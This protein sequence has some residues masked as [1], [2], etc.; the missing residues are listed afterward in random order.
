VRID[1]R[2][3]TYTLSY[4]P[5]TPAGMPVAPMS[6]PASARVVPLPTRTAAAPAARLTALAEKAYR[7]LKRMVLENEVHGGEYLL[8]EDLARI[9]G[10][11]RT[12]LR[13]ALVQ[14]QNEGLITIVPRR[15]VRVVPLTVEDMREVY[16]LLRWLESQAAHALACRT[17]RA[18]AVKG[19]R[20]LV[21]QMKKALAAN[22]IAGWARANDLFH[23]RLVESAGNQR[24]VRICAN[25]LDQSQR[26]RA[27]TLR[28]RK[29]PTR[30]TE[31]HAAMLKA[32]E[33]G[34]A[35]RAA[36]LQAQ[37]KQ[38][39]LAEFEDIVQRLQ[40]RYL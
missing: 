31:A 14:L 21:L 40:L 20:Q 3:L 8:E 28:L 6:S 29:P 38:A 13:E 25:L 1:L 32:I 9:V 34:D 36:T 7:E 12:P 18:A 4:T 39:W 35:D 2:R 24:L 11:S 30:T 5:F 37:N 19:L 10:M 22:D 23:I 27:F 15:G 26:V 17:D 16:E 33:D